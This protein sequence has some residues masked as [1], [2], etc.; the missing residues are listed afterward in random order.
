MPQSENQDGNFTGTF[1]AVLAVIALLTIVLLILLDRRRLSKGVSR[2]DEKTTTIVLFIL[3]FFVPFLHIASLF[4]SSEP[5]IPKYRCKFCGFGDNINHEFCMNCMRN[6]DGFPIETIKPYKCPHCYT[7]Q[8]KPF[9]YCPKCNK[10]ERGQTLGI[11][12]F[13]K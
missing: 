8:E 10:N 12:N 4:R 1:A 5:P 7:R 13:E 11:A 2:S 6:N 9:R 3:G